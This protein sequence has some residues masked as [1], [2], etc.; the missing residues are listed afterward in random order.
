MGKTQAKLVAVVLLAVGASAGGAAIVLYCR[1]AP[2]ASAGKQVAQQEITA[3]D[4]GGKA[5]KETTTAEGGSSQ[6]DPKSFLL[7]GRLARLGHVK[8]QNTHLSLVVVD[9][10]PLRVATGHTAVFPLDKDGT[11]HHSDADVE[12]VVTVTERKDGRL[13]V[14]IALQMMEPADHHGANAQH[15]GQTARCVQEVDL[16]ETVELDFLIGG[17]EEHRYQATFTVTEMKPASPNERSSALL[18]ESEEFKQLQEAWRRIFTL[19]PSDKARYQ[20][21]DGGIETEEISDSEES[22]RADDARQPLPRNRR[23]AGRAGAQ[24]PTETTPGDGKPTDSVPHINR[25]GNGRWE[26]VRILEGWMPYWVVDQPSHMTYQRTPGCI[27]P[28]TE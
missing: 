17:S 14:D 9:K 19:D 1:I 7:E 27:G 16:G 4:T 12:A 2:E 24:T 21:V 18:N 20:H 3:A 8:G 25:R 28:D 10:V 13:R 6:Q 15:R 11:L 23:E 26:D 5:N 22:Y